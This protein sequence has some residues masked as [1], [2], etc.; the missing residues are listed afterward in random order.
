MLS[1]YV[2]QQPHVYAPQ[3]PSFTDIFIICAVES[4]PLFES[5]VF[6]QKQNEISSLY[7]YTESVCVW[8]SQK[9]P[10]RCNSLQVV[11]WEREK[12]GE[13]KKSLFLPPHPP[14]KEF[15]AFGT[16]NNLCGKIM[17]SC[18]FNPV[19]RQLLVQ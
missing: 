5:F 1:N 18:V 15:V 9:T 12:K 2:S 4:F 17:F 13:E 8:V 3:E 7:V 6:Y 16:V 10:L 11:L 14:K 19:P